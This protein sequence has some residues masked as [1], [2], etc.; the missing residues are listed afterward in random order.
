VPGGGDIFGPWVV[1]LHVETKLDFLA[2][3]VEEG[4][5]DKAVKPSLEAVTDDTTR[6]G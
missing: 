2:G 4:V 3:A 5:V 1:D 6:Y